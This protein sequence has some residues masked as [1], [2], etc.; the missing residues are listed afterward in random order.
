MKYKTLR[1]GLLLVSLCGLASAVSIATVPKVAPGNTATAGAGKEWPATRFVVNG[2]C[3]TDNL[4]GLMWAK[5]GVIGFSDGTA[6][7]L[8]QPIYSNTYAPLNSLPISLAIIAIS[9]MNT[10]ATTKLCG[11]SDWRL[12]TINELKSLVNYRVPNPTDWLNT[13]GF[14]NVQADH[15]WS[16]STYAQDTNLKWG[17]NFNAGNVD[18]YGGYENYVWPVRG[19]Q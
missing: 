19:G 6:S 13:Q 14:T 18:T 2:D 8:D 16:S 3:V 15:Y 17:V 7:L 11:Y 9:N 12:P 1:V 10:A 5:N 4:T